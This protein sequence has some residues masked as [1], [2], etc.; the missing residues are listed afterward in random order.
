MWL[1]KHPKVTATVHHAPCLTSHD[2]L[3]FVLISMCGFFVGLLTSPQ[4]PLY[5]ASTFSTLE[6]PD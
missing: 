5:L 3:C 1:G 4:L 6:Q 2:A